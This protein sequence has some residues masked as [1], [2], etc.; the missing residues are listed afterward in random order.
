MAKVQLTTN[1]LVWRISINKDK[2]IADCS[3]RAKHGSTAAKITSLSTAQISAP[4]CR[5]DG[6]PKPT[7]CF[8]RQLVFPTEW[9]RYPKPIVYFHFLLEE[10]QVDEFK[11]NPNM[12]GLISRFRPDQ[13]VYVGERVTAINLKQGIR[14]YH[15][16]D[17]IDNWINGGVE[18]RHMMTHIFPL[19]SSVFGEQEPHRDLGMP[20]KTLES[21]VY[22]NLIERFDRS[23]HSDAKNQYL[24]CNRGFQFTR[25]N[26]I[27]GEIKVQRDK[28]VDDLLKYL[29]V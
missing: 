12:P 16:L 20:R 4:N 26:M 2:I 1:D 29:L 27:N 28:I 21:L 10:D 9:P 6:K 25:N 11:M 8:D 14:R 17:E 22:F 19:E 23:N 3:L 24:R 5:T 7:I 15:W 18:M 13:L